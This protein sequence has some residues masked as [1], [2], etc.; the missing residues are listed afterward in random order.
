[1]ALPFLTGKELGTRLSMTAAIDAVGDAF[2]GEVEP[3]SPPRSH[4]ETGDGDLLLMPAFGPE[5]AGV[6]LVTVNLDNPARGLPLVH[7][8]YV[9]FAPGTMAPVAVLDGAALTA[10]RTAAVS[11]LATRHLAR[12]D[13]HRL[14]I[15]GAGVQGTSH[16]EAMRAVRPVDR[17]VVVS[18]SPEPAEALVGRARDLGLRAEVGTPDAVAEADLVCACTTSATPVF[19]GR[20]VPAGTHVNAVGSYRPE[21]REVDDDLVRRARVVVETREA[22]LAEAGDL[23]IPLEAGTIGPDAVVGDLRQVVRG[24]VRGRVGD[25]DVTLFKSVGVAFEDLAVAAAALRADT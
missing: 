3:G 6:K 23:L 25:E 15:F 7:A 13:A 19:D 24:D 1:V 8:V 14:V 5:G 20:A 18:R 4:V 12:P 11:G 21:R 2:G 17:V 16:L 10:L 9:V 22:A